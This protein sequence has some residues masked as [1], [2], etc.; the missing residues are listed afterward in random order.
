MKV[1]RY[2]LLMIIGGIIGGL[3][4]ELFDIINQYNLFSKFHFKSSMLIISITLITTFFNI[5]LTLLL[6]KYQKDSLRLKSKS[7]EFE[8]E[9][10]AD[11]YERKANLK[12]L[13]VSF[14]FYLEILISFLTIFILALGNISDKYLFLSILPFI[15]TA[16]PAIMIG[17]FVRKFDDRYPKMGEEKYTEKI[18]EIMDEGE[19]HINFL[20]IYKQFF[21]NIG[22]L[23]ISVMFLVIY[24]IISKSNQSVGIIILIILFIYNAFGYLSKVRK[25]YKS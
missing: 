6:L 22:L 14:I 15:V 11:T 20:T 3:I 5:F 19:R 21:M 8:D 9:D 23:L 13:S 4:V 12:Y 2:L 16:I 7:I 18:I 10:I 24:S 17:L 1:G 25:F